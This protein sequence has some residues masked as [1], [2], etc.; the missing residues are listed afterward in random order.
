M[1]VEETEGLDYCCSCRA[2]RM[3]AH[4]LLLF[5]DSVA[6]VVSLR[7]VLDCR[8]TIHAQFRSRSSLLT[9]TRAATDPAD[10]FTWSWL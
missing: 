3:I 10:F 9:L 6:L 7:D 1:C 5:L 8:S 4:A 2:Q